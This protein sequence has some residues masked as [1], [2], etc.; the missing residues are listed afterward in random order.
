[1]LSTLESEAPQLLP[2]IP[3]ERWKTGGY[4]LVAR[5]Q[6]RPPGITLHELCI[7]HVSYSL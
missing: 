7:L 6:G 1:M 3:I 5:G 2:T 4:R